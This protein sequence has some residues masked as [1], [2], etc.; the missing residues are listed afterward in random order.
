MIVKEIPPMPFWIP[1]QIRDRQKNQNRSKDPNHSKRRVIR[2][3]FF[4]LLA[5]VGSFHQ[6]E[7]DKKWPEKNEPILF[8]FFSSFVS[9]LYY[10]AWTCSHNEAPHKRKPTQNKFNRLMRVNQHSYARERFVLFLSRFYRH[11]RH[12]PCFAAHIQTQFSAAP[13]S[14]HTYTTKI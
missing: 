11:A 14:R 8:P 12:V 1:L 10:N 2:G 13:H 4:F 6:H 9:W 7:S 5:G 3:C